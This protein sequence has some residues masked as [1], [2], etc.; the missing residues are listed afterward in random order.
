MANLSTEKKTMVHHISRKKRS[1]AVSKGIP[2]KP[3]A[4]SLTKIVPINPFASWN[5]PKHESGYIKHKDNTCL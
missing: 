4:P 5:M 1:G 3:T 2:A